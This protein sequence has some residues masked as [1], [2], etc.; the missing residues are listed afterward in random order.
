MVYVFPDTN[1]FIHGRYFE[2]IDWPVLVGS[3]D[4]TLML[5]PSVIAELD[6]HKYSPTKKVAQRAKKL[7]P[8]IE[9][10]ILNTANCK[11]N[12]TTILRRPDTGFLERHH[13][14]SKDQ[15]DVLLASILEFKETI[16]KGDDVILVT[17][18]TGPRLKAISLK[19]AAQS[20]PDDYLMPDEPDESEK[21]M[22]SLQK[23][24]EQFRNKIPL[25]SLE[26]ENGNNFLEIQ[27]PNVPKSEGEFVHEKMQEI[28]MEFL[29]LVFQNDDSIIL[30][31]GKRMFLP[32]SS[33]VTRAQVDLYNEELENFYTLYEEYFVKEYQQAYFLLNCCPVSIQIKN[34]GIVPAEDIDVLMHFPDGF[35]II[36]EDDIP[37]AGK[38]PS[39]PHKPKHAFDFQV[40]TPSID[41]ASLL[42]PVRHQADLSHFNANVGSPSVRKT[43]SYD[44]NV[45]IRSVK[46]N[47]S[48]QLDTLWL[49][50]DDMRNA[51]G[52]TIDYQIMAA[53]IPQ[54]VTGK[55]NVNFI[56][57]KD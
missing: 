42:H 39:P 40:S 52:F 3:A 10:I 23:E 30:P 18:D 8:K 5:A 47:Q 46:H 38:K 54:V 43:N 45:H 49:K 32:L 14:D 25:V 17:K 35:D 4:I 33:S 22:A 48:E 21:K 50:Y 37:S 1:I 36:K 26:F 27:R 28:L 19:I 9:A 53:N 34:T 13:L 44:V 6:K 16:G 7:L 51:K 12:V 57:K 55:L 2:E 41:L 56:E 11:W 15:D 29:P 20:L 24:L 31:G